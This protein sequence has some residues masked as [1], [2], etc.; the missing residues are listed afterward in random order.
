MRAILPQPHRLGIPAAVVG[1]VLGL[2]A[3]GAAQ[4]TVFNLTATDIVFES[5][6]PL[7][8]S[9][10]IT[11]SITLDDAIA[12][13]Q[14][15]GSASVTA[16]DLNFAGITGDLTSIQDEIAPGPVQLF[17]TRSADGRSFSV[18]DFRFGFTA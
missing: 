18:L 16:I 11:G 17:G 8:T 6:A 5:P 15:F 2:C 7:F 14:S 3:S 4:A 10:T 12:P 1:L 9:D 13:G